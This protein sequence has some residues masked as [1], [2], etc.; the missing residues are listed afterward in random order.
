MNDD[1]YEKPL[2]TAV[3]ILERR[4]MV[5]EAKSFEVFLSH[6]TGM[7]FNLHFPNLLESMFFFKPSYQQFERW[8]I[9]IIIHT[10][11]FRLV[12]DKER[13]LMM[14]ALSNFCCTNGRPIEGLNFIFSFSSDKCHFFQ[15]DIDWPFNLRKQLWTNYVYTKSISFDFSYFF[16]M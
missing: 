10:S 14:T 8:P 15:R 16:W 4:K 9:I 11:S 1:L 3:L 13:C 12:C 5:R 2:K 6:D 7:I